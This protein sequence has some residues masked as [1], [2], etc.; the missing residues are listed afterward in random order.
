MF[1]ILFIVPYDAIQL[2]VEQAV[3]LYKPKGMSIDLTNV[4]GVEDTEKLNIGI[5]DLIIARGITYATIK[6]MDPNKPIIEIGVT[7]FELIR[8]ISEAKS[9][10]NPKKK[11]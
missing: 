7:G 4:I 8:A 2:E 1:R 11:Q 5:Y 6:Q 3:N 10:Y 9:L